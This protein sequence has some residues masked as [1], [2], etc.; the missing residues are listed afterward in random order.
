MHDHETTP[1]TSAVA[2]SRTDAVLSNCSEI[3]LILP[4]DTS[5]LHRVREELEAAA[6]G[7]RHPFLLNQSIVN[8]DLALKLG[9]VAH[10]ADVSL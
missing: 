1:I 2:P 9:A 8:L 10:L 4:S 6:H 5:H 3:N 7:T